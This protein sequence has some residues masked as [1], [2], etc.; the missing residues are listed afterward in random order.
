MRTKEE[1]YDLV[2]QNRKLAADP[3][4]TKCTCPN[5]LCEWHGKCKECAALHRYHNDHIPVCLQPI[6]DDK[7]KSLAGTAE[8]AATKKGA[9]PVD[10]RLYVRERDKQEK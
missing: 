2:L 6:I 8:M 10:Y 4:I 5:N 1:Y 9:T 3:E 7:I